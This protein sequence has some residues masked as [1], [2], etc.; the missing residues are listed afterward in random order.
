MSDGPLCAECG[1]VSRDCRCT[2][3]ELRARVA[4]LEAEKDVGLTAELSREL[5]ALIAERVGFGVSTHPIAA[6]EDLVRGCEH[7]H[8]LF[9][10]MT[11][12]RDAAQ[13]RAAAAEHHAARADRVLALAEHEPSMQMRLALDEAIHW[14]MRFHLAVEWGAALLEAQAA[15]HVEAA[16]YFARDLAAVVA[17]RDALRAACADAASAMEWQQSL[18]RASDVERHRL[19]TMLDEAV[20]LVRHVVE[21]RTACDALATRWRDR[22]RVLLAKH[23]DKPATSAPKPATSLVETGEPREQ[24]C[25]RPPA[26]WRCTRESGHEGPCAAWPAFRLGEDDDGDP[27]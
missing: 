4:E 2:E 1:L 21:T 26:G 17:E 10:G 25:S 12:E 18:M 9:A 3:R 16:A 6:I 15:Q 13:A 11:R 23:D 27:A 7:W 20:H 5:L 8:E 19:E 22:A 24:A 14:H